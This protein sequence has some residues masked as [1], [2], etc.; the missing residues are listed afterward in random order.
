RAGTMW[1]YSGG[2]DQFPNEW[3]KLGGPLAQDKSIYNYWIIAFKSLK[4]LYRDF[5]EFVAFGI[6]MLTGLAREIYLGRK[7]DIHNFKNFYTYKQIA[8]VVEAD[9]LL[10]QITGLAYGTRA[11]KLLKLENLNRLVL[12]MSRDV[13]EHA[14]DAFQLRVQDLVV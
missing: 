5:D 13:S 2:Y 4:G 12:D 9:S 7:Y 11:E 10:K 3:D 1:D 8:P 6:E 14:Y